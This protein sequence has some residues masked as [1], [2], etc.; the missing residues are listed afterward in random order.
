MVGEPEAGATAEDDQE[1]SLAVER[2]P[3]P[4]PRLD[5]PRPDRSR[6]RRPLQGHEAAR[7]CAW[8]EPDQQVARPAGDDPRRCRRLRTHRRGTQ[9]GTW[10]KAAGQA[11]HAEP[12]DH[13][14]GA[15]ALAP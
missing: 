12:P 7:G 9:P 4:P 3:S 15:I 13:R 6:G 10:K 5:A 1:L 2:P 8:A 11:Q 14:A